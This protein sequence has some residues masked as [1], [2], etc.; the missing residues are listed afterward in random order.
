M[1]LFLFY[2]C[3]HKQYLLIEAIKGKVISSQN[4]NPIDNAKVFSDKRAFNAFDT[5]ITKKDGFFYWKNDSE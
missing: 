5:I 3:E 4:K 2:G 1:G